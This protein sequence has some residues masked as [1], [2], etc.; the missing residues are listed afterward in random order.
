MPWSWLRTSRRGSR[1]LAAA[2]LRRSPRDRGGGV[3]GVSQAAQG[4]AIAE[5]CARLRQQQRQHLPQP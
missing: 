1:P 3:A 4:R 5:L 2:S